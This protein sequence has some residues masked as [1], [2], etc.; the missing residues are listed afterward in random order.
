[1]R[2]SE[3]ALIARLR[4]AGAAGMG[5]RGQLGLGI[6]DDAALFLPRRGYETVLTCD[7]FLEG[8]HFLRDTHP[9]DSVGWKCLARAVS[10][11]A[12]MGAEPRCFLLSLALPPSHSGRWLD[13]FLHG[14]GRA[15]RKFKCGLAGGDTTR[16]RE[17]LINITAIGEVQAGRATLRSGAKSGDVLYVTGR[18][19]GAELGLRILTASRRSPRRN[20]TCVRKHLYPEARLGAAPWL[21]ERKLA[22]AMMDLSDG[23]SSDLSRLCSARGVG[24]RIQVA[25]IT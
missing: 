15:S 4:R 7:W 1:M 3:N 22:T 13:N 24:G 17:I 16:K 25:R 10:D 2:P 8:T 21:A 9:A 5:R 18:L 20:D 12:A 6:G 14:L 19:G 23:L 11:L